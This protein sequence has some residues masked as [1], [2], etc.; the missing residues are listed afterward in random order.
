M[1]AVLIGLA[2]LL[3][4]ASA[5]AQPDTIPPPTPTA[6]AVGAPALQ[7]TAAV[8]KVTWEAALDPPGNRPVPTY[9]WSAGF[10][11]GSGRLQGAVAGPVL[12][13]SMPYHASGA[14]SGFVCVLAEDAARNVSPGVACATLAIPAKP[15]PATT[16]HTIECREPTTN[17]DGT[18]LKDLASIRLYWRVD[19]G[20]ESA[21]TYPASSLTGGAVRLLRLTV[22]ATSGTL[23]VTVTAVDVSGNESARSAPATKMIRP[24]LGKE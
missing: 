1:R 24:T 13:L 8:F 15:A 12:M 9:R 19:G 11:D 4:A 23:S 3:V 21:V 7:P 14:A 22:P 6:L 18:P 10:S 17:A 20:P 16:A 5:A 2:L